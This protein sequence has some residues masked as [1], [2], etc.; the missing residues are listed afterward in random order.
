MNIT[1]L[2]K[3]CSCV[4][5]KH[6]LCIETVKQCFIKIGNSHTQLPS[7]RCSSF[8]CQSNETPN[9]IAPVGKYF[10]LSH[11]MCVELVC[12][13][14]LQVKCG[15]VYFY[16]LALFQSQLLGSFPQQISLVACFTLMLSQKS[17][18]SGA[19]KKLSVGH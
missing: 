16:R 6:Y 12:V 11:G 9:N 2:G 3:S 17:F 8:L 7:Q 4:L 15:C 5:I 14:S 1:T 10:L 13:V 18:S 19:L